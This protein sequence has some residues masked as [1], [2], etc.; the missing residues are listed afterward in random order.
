MVEG[1]GWASGMESSFSITGTSG[2]GVLTFE[3]FADE[4]FWRR[5]SDA[6]FFIFVPIQDQGWSVCK[7]QSSSN[8]GW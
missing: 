5:K 3:S 7:Q 1:I 6:N 2:T 4:V 8:D